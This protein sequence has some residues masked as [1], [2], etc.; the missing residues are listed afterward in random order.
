MCPDPIPTL[1]G[2]ISNVA[3]AVDALV[4]YRH[5]AQ[6]LLTMVD[7]AQLSGRLA[8]DREWNALWPLY[9]E[10]VDALP[11]PWNWPGHGD[12]EGLPGT[13]GPPGEEVKRP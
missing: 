6:V 8:Y 1:H 13:P 9:Y 2:V 3:Q 11:D 12:P 10:R 7:H 5:F 4:A